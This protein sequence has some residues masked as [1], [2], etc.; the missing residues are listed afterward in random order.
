MF[1]CRKD[2]AMSDPKPVAQSIMTPISFGELLDKITILEIKRRHIQDAGKLASVGHEL[3]LL[4]G[5]LKQLGVDREGPFKSIIDD[6]AAVNQQLWD[7]E[8]D[9]RDCERKKDFGDAFVKLARAVYFTNDRRAKLKLELNQGFGSD[10]V[11]VKSY[12]TY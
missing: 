4:E 12:A 8:D 10:L 6:L 2:L 1:F 5:V 7:I 11:E 9:I 3:D